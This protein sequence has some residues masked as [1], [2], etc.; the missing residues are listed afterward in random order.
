MAKKKNKIQKNTREP[1]INV[2]TLIF[3]LKKEK[4]IVSLAKINEAKVRDESREGRVT[5]P[6]KVIL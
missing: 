2:A 4:R 6:C 5:K 1:E 3:F